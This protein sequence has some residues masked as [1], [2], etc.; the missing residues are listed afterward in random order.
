M[1]MENNNIE[2]RKKNIEKIIKLE[3]EMFQKVEGIGGRAN[4]QEEWDTFRIMRESQFSCWTDDIIKSYQKDIEEAFKLGRNLIMEKYAYMMES[5]DHDYY[6]TKL[7]PYLPK[8]EIEK[9]NMIEEIIKYLLQWEKEFSEKYPK[10]SNNG[11]PISSDTDTSS[12]TSVETYTRGE[13]K[14]Y[15]KNTIKLYLDF[16]RK[17][18]EQGENI[19]AIVKDKTVKS[20]GYKSIDDAENRI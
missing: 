9:A 1:I 8:I 14:T 5:S 19:V 17:S 13:L 12:S 15:S 4:C 10:I 2:G 11:R 16:V 6:A 7:E 3:W 20:Y 18:K